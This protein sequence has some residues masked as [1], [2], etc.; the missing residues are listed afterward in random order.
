MKVP[1]IC[2]QLN[3]RVRK[4][5]PTSSEGFFKKHSSHCVKESISS[6]TSI[7]FCLHPPITIY[8]LDAEMKKRVVFG[9]LTKQLTPMID[10]IP[11][12]KEC[13]PYRNQHHKLKK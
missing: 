8:W 1:E 11:I 12:T 7:C 4:K 2:Q 6:M 3:S 10:I 5:C 13:N 9:I